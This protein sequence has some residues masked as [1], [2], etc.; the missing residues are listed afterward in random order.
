VLYT[1]GQGITGG[2]KVM[3]V[4]GS[5]LLPKPYTID[6]LQSILSEHFGIA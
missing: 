6:Q 4:E 5:A 3:M 2:M 1:T